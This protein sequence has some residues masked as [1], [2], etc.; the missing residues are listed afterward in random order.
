MVS[1]ITKQLSSIIYKTIILTFHSHHLSKH[2]HLVHVFH[3]VPHLF[4]L[5]HEGIYFADIFSSC[6][7]KSAK[8]NLFFLIL[9]SNF[10]ACSSSNCS[11]AFS[12]SEVISPIPKIR[13]AIRSG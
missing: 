4:E 8:S 1:K 11:C 10:F 3:H 12:T 5:F 9:L 2:I 6:C 13:W 7:L